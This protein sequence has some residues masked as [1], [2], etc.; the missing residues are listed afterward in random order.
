M[1]NR[2]RGQGRKSVESGIKTNL[3]LNLCPSNST[4]PCLKTDTFSIPL[5]KFTA[6]NVLGHTTSWSDYDMQ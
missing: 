1:C 5:I 4:T 3:Q 2:E 6:M